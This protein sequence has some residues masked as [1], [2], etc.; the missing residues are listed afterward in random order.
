MLR[1]ESLFYE[2]G[3]VAVKQMRHVRLDALESEIARF[4]KK[5]TIT[6]KFM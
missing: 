5:A 6:C 4:A 3:G 2:Y 1:F